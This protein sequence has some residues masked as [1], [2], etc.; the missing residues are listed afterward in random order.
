MRKELRVMFR[1]EKPHLDKIDRLAKRLKL[2]RSQTIRLSLDEAVGK[3]LEPGYRGEIITMD[4]KALDSLLMALHNRIME[5]DPKY[6]SQRKAK[7]AEEL[8]QKVKKLKA[9]GKK[10]EAEKLINESYKKGMASV[11]FSWPDSKGELT[12]EGREEMLDERYPDRKKQ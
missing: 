2:T 7:E 6:E 12:P 4:K 11:H 1:I 10:A 5:L 9:E 3:H 8:Y